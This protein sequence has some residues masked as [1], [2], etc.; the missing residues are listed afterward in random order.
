MKV[1]IK[2]LN[3]VTVNRILRDVWNPIG[4][5]DDLPEDEY[6]AYATTVHA[7]LRTGATPGVIRSYLLDMEIF[8]MGCIV[9]DEKRQNVIEA[10][11][12]KGWFER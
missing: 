9:S 6:E 11:R 1:K 8:A 4:F 2:P 7:M 3:V 10:F 12:A 5:H